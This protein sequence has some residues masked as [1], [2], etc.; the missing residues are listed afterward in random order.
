MIQEAKIID[1]VTVLHLGASTLSSVL[2]E[3]KDGDHP[4]LPTLHVSAPLAIAPVWRSPRLLP[5]VPQAEL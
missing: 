5:G 3:R 1:Q 4:S 2:L